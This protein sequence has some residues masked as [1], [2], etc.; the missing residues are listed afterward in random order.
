MIYSSRFRKVYRCH[1]LKFALNQRK[2]YQKLWQNSRPSSLLN[3]PTSS[4]RQENVRFPWFQHLSLNLMMF[5]IPSYRWNISHADPAA[6]AVFNAKLQSSC[7]ENNDS[8]GEGIAEN[9]GIAKDWRPST[10]AMY[11]Q[12]SC[13]ITP[14]LPPMKYTCLVSDKFVISI[15][16]IT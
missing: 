15:H 7:K 3:T 5:T 8:G 4:H 1:R 9:R 10:S 13:G 2:I 6:V 16:Q 14:W 11:L 12:V